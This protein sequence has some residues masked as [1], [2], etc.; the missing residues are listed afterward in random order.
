MK[1]LLTSAGLK[2]QTITNSLFELL[3][4]SAS[5]TKVV[6]IPTAANIFGDD[7]GWLIKNYRE[8]QDLRFASVDICDISAVPKENWQPRIEIADLIIVGGGDTFYI[9]KWVREAGLAE[10]LPELLKTR[11]YM[12]ISAG[13]MI[14]G[15]KILAKEQEYYEEGTGAEDINSLGFIDFIIFPHYNSSD[16]PKINAENMQSLA[17]QTG[18]QIYALDDNSAIIVDGDKTEVV[19]E[20]KWEKFE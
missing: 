8:L 3:G 12:G 9:E 2:N 11:V 13:S 1:L 7:K 6:F 14:A 16:F 10:M 20:G 5:E 4:K 18:E 19:S 17:D 15:K